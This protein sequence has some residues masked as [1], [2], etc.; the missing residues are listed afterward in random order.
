M[1]RPTR[2]PF[3]HSDLGGAFGAFAPGFHEGGEDVKHE[4]DTS[5]PLFAPT[6]HQRSSILSMLIDA[7]AHR[8]M[9]L[10]SSSRP[11]EPTGPAFGLPDDRLRE[12]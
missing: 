9:H 12:R 2:T 10:D 7:L 1:R 3:H 11:R 8:R 4:P 5:H 6:R